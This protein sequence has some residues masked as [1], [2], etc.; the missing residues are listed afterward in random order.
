MSLFD[1]LKRRNVF[2]VATAYLVASWLI[3]QVAETILP[4]YGF[5]GEAIRLVISL[6]AVALVPVLA[7]SWVFE[8]TPKGLRREQGADVEQ[9]PSG[10]PVTRLDRVIL[11]LLALALGYFAFDKFII[12][13]LRDQELA[14]AV[15]APLHFPSR[16]ATLGSRRLRGA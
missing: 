15:R 10:G 8:F 14:E 11:V 7:F 9:S 6:L 13:P 5:G 4:A 3:I 16:G 12:G 1:E 2:R